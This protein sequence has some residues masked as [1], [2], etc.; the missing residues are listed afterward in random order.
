MPAREFRMMNTEPH[1]NG[2]VARAMPAITALFLLAG[3]VLAVVIGPQTRPW[4]W[5]PSLLALGISLASALPVFWKRDK[6]SSGF[7]L[8]AFGVTVAGWFAW[9]ACNS[10][11]SDLGDADLML[12]AAAGGALICI[13]AIEENVLA[14][15]ILIWGIALL[16]L[17]N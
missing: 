6:T 1:R 11:V 7:G 14:E 15:T 5:G 17:A 2:P 16:L 10:P 9:R 4:T 8:L 13:R 3:L 12:L